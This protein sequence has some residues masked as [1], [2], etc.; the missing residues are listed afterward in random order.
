MVLAV[1]RPPLKPPVFWLLLTALPPGATQQPNHPRAEKRG[2]FFKVTR[3]VAEVTKFVTPYPVTA[4]D[5]PATAA[6][7]NMRTGQMGRAARSRGSTADTGKAET[8]K[9]GRRTGSGARRSGGAS[10]ATLTCAAA[11]AHLIRPPD[12]FSP[13]NAEKGSSRSRDGGEQL[14]GY[15]D[16]KAVAKRLGVKPKTVSAWARQGR[17]PAYRVGDYLR[18]SWPEIE[19]HLAASCRVGEPVAVPLA[20][21]PVRENL[22]S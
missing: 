7:T 17:L 9:L 6:T 18:F 10:P 8:L 21:G 12:T 4:R 2:I 22:T 13:S 16:K 1:R 5:E 14:E 11:D 19:Q 20:S 15:L 3:F